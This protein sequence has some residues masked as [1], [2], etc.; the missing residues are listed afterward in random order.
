LGKTAAGFVCAKITQELQQALFGD[1]ETRD[2]VVR[3]VVSETDGSLRIEHAKLSDLVASATAAATSSSG[4]E[5]MRRETPGS[6]VSNYHGSALPAVA[7]VAILYRPV[8]DVQREVVSTYFSRPSL[9]HIAAPATRRGTPEELARLDLETLRAGIEMLTDLHENKF[10]LRLSFPV[11]FEAIASPPR[12][13]SYME[14]CRA[15][16]EHVRKLVAFELVDLPV[17]VL[18]GRL[19]ELTTALRPWCGLVLATVDWWRADL[20]QFTNTGIRLVNAVVA[21]G[22]E[23]KRTLADMDR[24]ALAAGKA[25]LQSAVEGVGTSSLALAAKGAGVDFI[26]GDRIAPCL[27]IPNHMLRISW[28]EVYFGKGG[29]PV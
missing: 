8:W 15:I 9:S 13:R 25:G 6:P 12:F 14:L 11:G 24:F 18:Y 16:P 2:V 5:L 17:G 1:N 27:E 22:G 10:R 26:S 3:T 29:R 23:E 28:N 7:D 19:A 21:A 20:S 4:A